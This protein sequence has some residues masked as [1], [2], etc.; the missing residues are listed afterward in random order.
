MF[1]IGFR[2]QVRPDNI[3]VISRFLE[4]KKGEENVGSV[5]KDPLFDI[6]YRQH[7][8]RHGFDMAIG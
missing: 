3:D 8:N 5:N 6:V 2:E 4:G 7:I 1:Q